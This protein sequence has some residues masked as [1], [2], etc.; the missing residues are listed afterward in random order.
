[1]LNNGNYTILFSLFSILEIDIYFTVELSIILSLLSGKQP[2]PFKNLF[3][4]KISFNFQFQI[5]KLL[6]LKRKDLFYL[7]I[8]KCKL[9][10]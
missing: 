7:Q 9:Y 1:M 5:L 10:R 3:V 6:L 8:S 2:L 4:T